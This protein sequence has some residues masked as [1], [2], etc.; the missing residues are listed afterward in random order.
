MQNDEEIRIHRSPWAD[1][2]ATQ[3]SLASV[4]ICNK[5]TGEKVEIEP[6]QEWGR[7][8]AWNLTEDGTGIMMLRTS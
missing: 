5:S 6:P 4:S 7:Y 2:Y 3:E 1:W 8:W